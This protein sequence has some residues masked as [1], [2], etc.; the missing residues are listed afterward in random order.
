MPNAVPMF[1]LVFLGPSDV[2]AIFVPSWLA[3]AYRMLQPP[4]NSTPYTTR[5]GPEPYAQCAMLIAANPQGYLP[6]SYGAGN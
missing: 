3:T 6:D 4:G 5:L 1:W 2:N